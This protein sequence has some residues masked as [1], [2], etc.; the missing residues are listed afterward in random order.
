MCV[1][2]RPRRVRGFAIQ[3]EPRLGIPLQEMKRA[4]INFHI[5]PQ[6]HWPMTARIRPDGFFSPLAYTEES[7][8]LPPGL[9][10]QISALIEGS[11]AV[12]LVRR[13]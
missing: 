2:V 5:H 1:C 12:A 13:S 7:V 11:H 6:K 10:S 4:Q 3:V 8:T 9:R